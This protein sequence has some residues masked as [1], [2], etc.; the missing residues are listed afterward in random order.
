MNERTEERWNEKGRGERKRGG[1]K[2]ESMR[3]IESVISH[4]F[5][6]ER[7]EAGWENRAKTSQM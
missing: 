4:T 7:E 2:I 1:R 6:V 3:E 5:A